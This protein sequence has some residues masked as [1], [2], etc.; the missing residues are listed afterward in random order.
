MN[1]QNRLPALARNY[2]V[3]LVLAWTG[4]IIASFLWNTRAAHKD[5]FEKARIEARTLYDLNLLYRRWS[6][7]HGG[8]YVPVTDTLQPNPYL[9]F[10]NRDVT[11]TGGL[12]L[13]LVNP[14]WMTR[15]VF[16]LFRGKEPSSI[17]TRLSSLKYIN[18]VNKPDAWEER[19]L[20][21]FEQGL[22]ELSEIVEINEQPY[23]KLMR[24]FIT[25]QGCLKCHG[26]QGYRVGEIRGGMTVAIPMKP[27]FGVA[28]EQRKS[29]FLSHALV[30]LIGTAGIILFSRNIRKQQD[31]LGKSEQ[32]YRLLFESNPH[33][34]W[35]YDLENLA[36]LMVNNAAVK[37][38]GYSREE[39]L[40]MTIKDIRPPE[41]V[42][43]LIENVTGVTEGIDEAGIWRHRKKDGAVIFA[44][45]TSHVL[46]FQGRRAELVLAH[47][48]TERRRLEDQLLQAQ[49]MEAVGLLAGGIAHDFNNILSAIIGYGN[50]VQ[51]KMAA[52]DPLR[53]HIDHI[54]TSAER[55]AV[56]TQSLLAFSRKQIIN[57]QPVNVND[58]I[59]K[60]EKL[61]QRLIR[62]DIEFTTRRADEDII[63]MA[64]AGQLEQVLM[65]LATNARDAMPDGGLLTIET[66]QQEIGEDFIRTHNYGMPGPYAV[67]SVTDT[68]IGMDAKTKERIFEP[69]FTTKE[70]G[71]GTGLGLAIV[72]GIVKQHNGYINV[73]SEPGTG[74]TFKI[75]LP[76]SSAAAGRH[77]PGK[78]TELKRGTETVLVAEDDEDLRDLTRSVLKEFGY[79]IIMAENGEDAVQKFLVNK[80]AV[81]LLILDVIM[82]KKNGKEVYEEAKAIRPGI[83]A[84]FISGYTADIVHKKGFLDQTLHFISKPFSPDELLRKVRDVLD[85]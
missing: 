62:E 76:V 69:F 68:G 45:I 43:A 60:M 44:D 23:L 18:P 28:A 19:G 3:Y 29:T 35:V 78:P 6:A 54:L 36:F 72:Y 22:A 55:A 24:P 13:T 1:M 77:E 81:R 12:K 10:P 2:I 27:Y 14:A 66:K 70:T 26:H 58:C 42:P 59:A 38:Y 79:T 63:V 25:E 84:L 7:N 48:V 53:N 4:V 47:D 11:T 31:H 16:E 32:K 17:V 51:M 8:V 40:A 83:K 9:N 41:D 57:P 73:Y 20:R 71:K 82:P 65:N 30:W 39:F 52:D 15:Q 33:P 50:L 5:L 34:M 85:G 56:L 46:T 67:I 75:Y 37:K 49:K 21:A 61:L 64:D 80:D 74:T